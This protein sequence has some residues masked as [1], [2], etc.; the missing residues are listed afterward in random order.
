[1]LSQWE[2]TLFVPKKPTC[3]AD[4]KQLITE[5]ELLKPVNVIARQGFKYRLFDLRAN[6]V[7][8]QLE[9]H[10][11]HCIRLKTPLEVAFEA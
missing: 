9:L 6:K 1:M 8:K 3:L 10:Y 7:L 5:R 11:Y 4:I 2:L